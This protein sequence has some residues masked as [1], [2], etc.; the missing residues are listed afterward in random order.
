MELISP[1]NGLL[2][3]QGGTFL[4]MIGYFAFMI[5][6]LVDLIRSDFREQHMKLIWALMILFIPVIG[7]FIYLNMRRST[8][9]NFRRFDPN[10]S[11]NQKTAK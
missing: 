11:T 3:W 2:Y 7:T 6:A 10:F 1:S 4:V 9:N 8:K 5:Y